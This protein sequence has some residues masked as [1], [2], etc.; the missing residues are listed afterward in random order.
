[1]RLLDK[2]IIYS[3][4]FALFSEDFYF[5]YGIDVKLFYLILISNFL[6]LSINKKITVPKNLLIILGFFIGHGIISY[7]W[8]QNPI[9]SLFAQVLGIAMSSIYYYNFIK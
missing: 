8:L 4:I 2:Y 6:L 3:S 5:H 1:M 9:K 7:L